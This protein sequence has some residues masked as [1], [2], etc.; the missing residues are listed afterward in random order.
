M[1][2]VAIDP[3]GRWIASAGVDRVIRLW[4]LPDGRPFHALPY[5]EIL[6]RLRGATNYRAVADAGAPTGF[7]LEIAPFQ[8]WE[9]VPTW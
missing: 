9:T 5:E 1:H 4:P 7:R 8:G 2:A 6:E 3:R